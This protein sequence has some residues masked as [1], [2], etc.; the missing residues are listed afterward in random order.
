VT[1]ILPEEKE[2]EGST[3]AMSSPAKM[4]NTTNGI[5]DE[6]DD[7]KSVATA[8]NAMTSVTY[9]GQSNLP[10][11]PI[12][13]LE[14]TLDKFLQSL[15]AL[16][17][18]EEQREAAKQVVS[19]FLQRDGPRLQ[20]LLVEYDRSG[21]KT[22]EIGSYVEEFWNDSYLAPDSSVVLVRFNVF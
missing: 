3:T 9:G 21:R 16:H 2:V 15:E 10:P 7:S 22:G 12:P 6:Q 20:D 5:T 14:E 19:D 13:R 1:V 8:K 17:E 18:C 4:R 11:L